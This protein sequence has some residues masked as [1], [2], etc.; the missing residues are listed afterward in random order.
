MLTRKGNDLL[1]YAAVWWVCFRRRITAGAIVAAC[2][3]VLGAE[4]VVASAATAQPVQA[5][6]PNVLVK[7]SL[8]TLPATQP[9]ASASTASTLGPV[10]P[11]GISTTND[12][13][14]W[15]TLRERADSDPSLGAALAAN[16]NA[17]SYNSADFKPA[18]YSNGAPAS[19]NSGVSTSGSMTPS[20]DTAT[21]TAGCWF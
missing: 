13:K 2:L 1:K 21:S 16:A 8:D 12:K 5:T 3:A 7:S 14:A 18:G 6:T 15:A 4:A 20:Q 9:I 19:T 11:E 10:V 17:S